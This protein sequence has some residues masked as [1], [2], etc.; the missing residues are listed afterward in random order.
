MAA[1]T[2]P[3]ARAPARSASPSSEAPSAVALDPAAAA[4]VGDWEIPAEDYVL[5]LIED[6][7]FVQDYMGIT[8][9]RTGKYSVDGR[10]HLP[11]RR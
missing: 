7:T 3:R 6:G 11:R 5:H 4:L 8:D 2:R 10:H 9:F 1:P